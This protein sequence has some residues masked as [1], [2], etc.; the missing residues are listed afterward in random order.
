MSYPDRHAESP[1]EDVW[2]TVVVETG[3]AGIEGFLGGYDLEVL[4]TLVPEGC[5]CAYILMQVTN[6]SSIESASREPG[7]LIT[8]HKEMIWGDWM[9]SNREATGGFTN[10]TQTFTWFEI[11]TW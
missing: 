10:T 3:S 4:D 9:R 6:T 1:I 5:R 2:N 7:T 11:V 8:E